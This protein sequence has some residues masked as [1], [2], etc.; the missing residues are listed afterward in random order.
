MWPPPSLYSSTS[1]TKWKQTASTCRT[2]SQSFATTGSSRLKSSAPPPWRPHRHT[3]HVSQQLDE[4]QSLVLT[5]PIQHRFLHHLIS[6]DMKSRKTQIINADVTTC[7]RILDDNGDAARE[8][9][10][11]KTTRAAFFNWLRT[12]SGVLHLSGNPGSGKPTLMKFISQ[13]ETTSKEL[14][15]WAGSCQL[16]FAQST[17]LL[18][19]MKARVTAMIIHTL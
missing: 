3:F 18:G 12:G 1:W 14:K 8:Q 17:V 5:I 19:W 4:I 15:V 7:K 11:R 2:K 6:S 16:V 13:H 9:S 10:S